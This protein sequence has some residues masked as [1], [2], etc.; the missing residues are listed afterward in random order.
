VLEYAQQ[1]SGHM[2]DADIEEHY[3]LKCWAKVDDAA[4]AH[5]LHD[6]V[7]QHLRVIIDPPVAG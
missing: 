2:I 1:E 3:L 5:A 6:A 4:D 7:T